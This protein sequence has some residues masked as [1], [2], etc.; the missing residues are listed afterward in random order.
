MIYNENDSVRLSQDG[1]SV[2]IID[3]T[4]LP[5]EKRFISLSAAEEIFDAIYH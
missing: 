1:S 5:A 4:L 3:Q 2:V